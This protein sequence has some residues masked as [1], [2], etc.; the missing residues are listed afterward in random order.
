[1][2]QLRS[3]CVI[4]RANGFV[5][6]VVIRREGRITIK[7]G[8]L[9][10]VPVL[11]LAILSIILFERNVKKWHC[12]RMDPWV[13]HNWNAIIVAVEMPSY[14]ASFRPKPIVLLFYSVDNRAPVKVHWKT[15]TGRSER[16]RCSLA[17]ARISFFEPKGSKPVA[18]V[19]SRSLLSHMAREDSDGAGA[20]A[21]STDHRSNDQSSGGIVE[22]T[23]WEQTKDGSAQVAV[24]STG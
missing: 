4:K 5:M 3:W 17:A 20:T 12:T 18:T 23:T 15:W 10:S 7:M 2:I 14:L 21:C 16:R 13:K 19:D 9:V 8:L 22:G 11:I 1:M 24:S 6:D